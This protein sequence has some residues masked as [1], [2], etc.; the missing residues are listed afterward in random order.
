MGAM[1]IACRYGWVSVAC[2]QKADGTIDPNTL[3]IRARVL[4]HLKNLQK[5]FESLAALPV[6]TTPHNDYCYRLVV[7]KEVWAKV[8]VELVMEQEWSNFKQ[9]AARF[10]GKDA[11]RYSAALHDVWATMYRLQERER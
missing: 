11:R 7:S 8:M 2:A 9:E 1:W 3:M 4:G 5:R 10:G 6:K